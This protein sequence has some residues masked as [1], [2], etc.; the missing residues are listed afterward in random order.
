MSPQRKKTPGELV[1]ES[2]LRSGEIDYQTFTKFNTDELR[3]SFLSALNNK[4]AAPELEEV[5]MQ[6]VEE[7]T[8]GINLIKGGSTIYS[9]K[10]EAARLGLKPGDEVIAVGSD[11]T[12]GLSHYKVVALSLKAARPCVLTIRRRVSINK[13]NSPPNN[14]QTRFPHPEKLGVPPAPPPTP[15]VRVQQVSTPP[16]PRFIPASA[17]TPAP[18]PVKSPWTPHTPAP[19]AWS[20][21]LDSNAASAPG[22]PWSPQTPGN[23]GAKHSIQERQLLSRC[24]SLRQRSVL[25]SEQDLADNAA[26]EVYGFSRTRMTSRVSEVDNEE[27]EE[28]DNEEE[29][30]QKEEELEEEQKEEKQKEEQKGQERKLMEREHKIIG[31]SAGTPDQA[32]RIKAALKAALKAKEAAPVYPS[33]WSALYGTQARRMVPGHWPVAETAVEETQEAASTSTTSTSTSTSSS[34]SSSSKRRPT[35]GNKD[36]ENANAMTPNSAKAWAWV[37]QAKGK[38]KKAQAKAARAQASVKRVGTPV[39]VRS[40]GWDKWGDKMKD[41]VKIDTINGT[42]ATLASRL[43][44]AEGGNSATASPL[45]TPLAPQLLWDSPVGFRN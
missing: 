27:E 4:A 18:T 42:P 20:K 12:A 35:A 16:T 6:F 25:A 5:Q 21:C 43:A 17:P 29:E 40:P 14:M 13:P 45:G 30:E 39:S 26:G 8:F 33:V 19:D 34:S 2:L 38:A 31:Q 32:R 3:S 1:M 36:K 37:A 41:K 15:Q 9:V 28:D 44:A 7:G 22:T 11:N 23:S 24:G 10:G